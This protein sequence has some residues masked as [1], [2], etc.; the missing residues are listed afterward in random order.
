[1]AFFLPANRYPVYT[2]RTVDPENLIMSFKTPQTYLSVLAMTAVVALGGCRRGA[3]PAQGGPG[4]GGTPPPSAVKIVTLQESPIEDTSEFIATIRSLRSMTVQPEVEGFITRILVKSG[5]RVSAGDSLVQINQARQEAAVS[6]VEATRGGA[7][8]DVQYWTQQVK[9]L[10]ALVDAGAVSKAEFDQA[11]TSLRTAQAQLTAIDAQ[12]RQGR[13]E[14]RFYRVT[15]P[16][17]GTIGDI[18]VRT[19]DRVTTSTVITTIDDRSGLEAYIQVP[20]DRSPLLRVGLPVRLLDDNNKVVGTNPVTFVAP[21]VDDATQTVLVKTLLKELPPTLR[22]LQFV[23]TQIVWRNLQG[24]RVPVT[25]VVRISGQYFAYVAESGPNNSLVAKQRPIEV[26]DVLDNDYIVRSGL[27]P[28][29]KLI[30]SGIQ[31]IG[32]GAPV[33]GE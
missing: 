1:V 8:A 10:G 28:G 31:K 24:L 4:A 16:Q 6:N 20:L 19:G 27:K 15:A 25:A 2:R 7:E 17:A 33:R 18:P 23:R 11:Q 26:G 3:G 22:V 29:E 14:L 13:V 12:V 9:R 5:D 30:V 32:D 21:R